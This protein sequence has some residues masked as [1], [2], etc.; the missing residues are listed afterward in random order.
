MCPYDLQGWFF[1][2]KKFSLELS[3]HK[4]IKIIEVFMYVVLKLQTDYQITQHYQIC[5]YECNVY[6]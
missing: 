4:C 5:M 1:H 2:Y 6:M 3:R